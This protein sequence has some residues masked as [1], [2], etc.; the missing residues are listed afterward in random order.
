MQTHAASDRRVQCGDDAVVVAPPPLRPCRAGAAAAYRRSEQCRAFRHVDHD[1][2][3]TQSKSQRLLDAVKGRREIALP[4]F[5]TGSP[6]AFIDARHARYH[7]KLD[8]EKSRY[9]LV[10]ERVRAP[11]VLVVIL[12]ECSSEQ[13]SRSARQWQ[14]HDF[15]AV[16]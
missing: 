11:I 4:S 14:R 13:L 1:G 2:T 5:G 16:S 10:D 15:C 7:A 9:P 12:T 6:F 3:G 8:H